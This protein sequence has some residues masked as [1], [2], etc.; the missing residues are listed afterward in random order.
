MSNDGKRLADVWCERREK[1]LE[2]HFIS[3]IEEEEARL[4]AVFLHAG[5]ASKETS[6]TVRGGIQTLNTKPS[7]R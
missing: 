5:V 6:E 1:A 3:L 7:T 2:E 4:E